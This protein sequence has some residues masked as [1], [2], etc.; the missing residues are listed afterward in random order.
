MLREY[1]F[2]MNERNK[3][4]ERD[5]DKGEEYVEIT[6]FETGQKKR[7]KRMSSL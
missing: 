3:A 7:I 4:Y 6:D 1:R 2:I 5:E